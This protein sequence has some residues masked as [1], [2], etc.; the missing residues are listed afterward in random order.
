MEDFTVDSYIASISDFC[1]RR[2]AIHSSNQL[3][4]IALGR[5]GLTSYTIH[6]CRDMVNIMDFEVLL[7]DIDVQKALVVRTHS[8]AL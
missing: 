8:P 1:A 2:Y 3:T 4:T 7:A 5:V 6:S